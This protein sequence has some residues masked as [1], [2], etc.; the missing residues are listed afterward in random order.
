MVALIEV[1]DGSLSLV[2]SCG[3]VDSQQQVSARAS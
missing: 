2:R 1:I 3:S